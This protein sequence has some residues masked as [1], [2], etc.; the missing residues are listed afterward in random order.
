M[1]HI[2]WSDCNHV[3]TTWYI[4]SAGDLAFCSLAI[5][6]ER[7]LICIFRYNSPDWS[8]RLLQDGFHFLLTIWATNSELY[9]GSSTHCSTPTAIPS[10]RGCPDN[11]GRSHHER[12]F[13]ELR[14]SVEKRRLESFQTRL[15]TR[16]ENTFSLRSSSLYRKGSP[17]YGWCARGCRLTPILNKILWHW[18]KMRSHHRKVHP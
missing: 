2:S 17:S 13:P 15:P 6:R 11:G 14:E 5:P 10:A 8:E 7:L 4:I 1:E 9:W 18:R 12:S 16:R 3:C